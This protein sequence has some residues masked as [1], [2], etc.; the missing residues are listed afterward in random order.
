MRAA[1][2]TKQASLPGW[3]HWGRTSVSRVKASRPA[4][5]RVPIRAAGRNRTGC[6]PGTSWPLSQMS[7]KGIVSPVRFERTLPTASGWCLLSNWATRTWSLWTASNRLPPAHET[8][9]L[10]GELQRLGYRGWNRTSVSLGPSGSHRNSWG[11]RIRTWTGVSVSRSRAGR[12]ASYT[13]PHSHPATVSAGESLGLR[14]TVR[15]Q[16]S[17]ILETIVLRVSEPC[18]GAYQP[19]TGRTAEA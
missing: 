18:C 12:V 19:T 9:A 13:I 5:S 16:E 6:L 3:G 15:A 7:Y 1:V 11:T 8:G 10:P 2:T 17:Q 14:L 4:I